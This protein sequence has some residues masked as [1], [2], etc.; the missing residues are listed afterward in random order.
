MEA[1]DGVGV[2]VARVVED[3]RV[4][5][6][7]SVTEGAAKRLQKREFGGAAR[8]VSGGRRRGATGGRRGAAGGK[9]ASEGSRGQGRAENSTSAAWHVCTCL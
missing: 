1:T 8:K 6:G 9:W 4:R 2:N 7:G 5:N 3:S